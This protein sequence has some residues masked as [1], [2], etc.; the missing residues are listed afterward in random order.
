MY[1]AVGTLHYATTDRTYSAY[2]EPTNETV[3]LTLVQYTLHTLS[4]A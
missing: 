3:G 1:G 4:L 2:T